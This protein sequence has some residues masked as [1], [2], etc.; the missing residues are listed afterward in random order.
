LTAIEMGNGDIADF[1]TGRLRSA[2]PIAT[3]GVRN[4]DIYRRFRHQSTSLLIS[5]EQGEVD[6]PEQLARGP[7]QPGQHGRQLRTGKAFHLVSKVLD[8]STG[9]DHASVCHGGQ[10]GGASGDERGHCWFST[11]IPRAI[12]SANSIRF[13]V[14]NQ[15]SLPQADTTTSSFSILATAASLDLIGSS[16][17]AGR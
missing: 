10:G 9:R 7:G 4:G 1:V 5:S 3:S 14:A 12:E 11:V 17:C 16:G 6:I 8:A 15:A 2:N 13:P